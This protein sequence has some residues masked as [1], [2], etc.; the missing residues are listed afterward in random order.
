[1]IGDL[2]NLNR[3]LFEKEFEEL[4]ER[5]GIL[6]ECLKC[7]RNCKNYDA[8]N[9]SFFWCKDFKKDLSEATKLFEQKA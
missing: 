6:K 2:C 3:A 5:Y 9:L 4:K 7:A 8:P 1:M